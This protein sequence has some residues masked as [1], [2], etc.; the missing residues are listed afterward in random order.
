MTTL[1]REVWLYF[2]A[3]ST[4]ESR[5]SCHARCAD[6]VSFVDVTALCSKLKAFAGLDS[7]RVKSGGKPVISVS[8][9][10]RL[11]PETTHSDEGTLVA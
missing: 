6:K 9:R 3:N 8:K 1:C 10:N 5:C 7:R 2:L 4:F 11:V